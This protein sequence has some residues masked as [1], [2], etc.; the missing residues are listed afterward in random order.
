ME[1]LVLSAK[2][3]SELLGLSTAFIYKLVREN[4]IP[5]KKISKRV[6]FSKKVIEEWLLENH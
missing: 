4:G 2:E 6:V 3:V 1:K 5:H